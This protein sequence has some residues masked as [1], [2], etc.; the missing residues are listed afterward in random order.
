[1]SCKET[2]E[3]IIADLQQ[4]ARRYGRPARV[5]ARNR[6]RA[7][8]PLGSPELREGLK[9]VDQLLPARPRTTPRA[10]RWDRR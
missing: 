9:Y 10:K 3:R 2:W 4:Q 8:L 1:M 5:F 7:Q 6:L